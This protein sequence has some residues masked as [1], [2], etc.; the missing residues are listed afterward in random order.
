MARADLPTLI[1]AA[2]AKIEAGAPLSEAEVLAFAK[3]L[4]AASMTEVAA[5]NLTPDIFLVAETLLKL[6]A[7]TGSDRAP[8]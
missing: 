6:K 7:L 3:E 2:N 8:S 1:A 5:D 4:V